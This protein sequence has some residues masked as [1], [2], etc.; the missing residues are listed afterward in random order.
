M[1]AQTAPRACVR[2][3][4]AQ[5]DLTLLRESEMAS[6][7]V[8]SGRR[9]SMQGS[10]SAVGYFEVRTVAARYAAQTVADGR[11]R[12]SA[13]A[14]ANLATLALQDRGKRGSTHYL[15]ADAQER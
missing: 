5:R 6:I 14:M 1:P 13:Q 3:S 12:L 15:H 11:P 7:H 9:S 2:I 10:Y 8:A 4:A